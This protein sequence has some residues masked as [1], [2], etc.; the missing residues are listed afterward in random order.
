MLK[1][2]LNQRPVW[3]LILL[4]LMNLATIRVGSPHQSYQNHTDCQNI[5][6]SSITYFY[7]NADS[8]LNKINEL[9]ARCSL[10]QPD[11]LIISE[12]CPKH[13]YVTIPPESLCLQGYDLFCSDFSVAGVYACI[14]N[15]TLKLTNMI[16]Q[17]STIL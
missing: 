13:Y 6:K 5:R 12:V 3:L 17:S 8:L 15:L 11:I 1:L 4:L 7:T 16:I 10:L 2:A 14:V 9:K